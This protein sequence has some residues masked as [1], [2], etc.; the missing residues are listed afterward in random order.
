M[1]FEPPTGMPTVF[2]PSYK[3]VGQKVGL[4]IW[5]VEK[6]KI[7][8]KPENEACYQGHFHEGDAYIILQ[9]KKKNNALERHI[10]FWLGKDSS[11]DEQGVAAYKTVE[12][13]ESLGGEPV[14]H[15]EVQGHETDQFL[16]LFKGGVRYLE[17]GV[18][19]G[20]KHV[21][22]D[23]FRLR[24]LHLKGRRNV[25]CSEVKVDPKS[26]NE[27]DVF[28]ADGGRKLVLWCGKDASRVEKCKGVQMAQQIRDQERSGNAE[29]VCVE[30]GKDETAFW[31]TLGISKPARITS[32]KDGG[33]D[34]AHSRS[35]ANAIKLFK[36]SDA[37]G[38]L[39][40][41][42]ITER[43]LKKE[44]LDTNDSFVLNT[45]GGE[46]IF[47]W[48]GKKASQGEKLH[49]MKYATEYLKNSGLPNHTPI[50]RV[51]EGTETP[52]FKQSFESWPEANALKPGAV[53]SGRKS[54]EKKAFDINSMKNPGQRE[55]YHLPDDGTG[56]LQIWRIEDFE[57]AEWPKERYG[58]FYAGDS[59]V[60]LYTYLV[61]DKENYIVYFWQGLDSSQD[62]K[63]AS[64]LWAKN[65]DDELGG[66]AVQ[67]RVV[68]NKEPPHFYLIFKGKFI[69]H[70]GGKASGFKNIADKDSYDTDGVSLY[71][72]RGTNETN[73]RAIQ[74]PEKA[75]SLNSGD[76]FLL[77][78]PA[79]F[80]AW[81]GSQCSG[82]E[83][84]MANS[85]FGKVD[86][87]EVQKITEG[88]EPTPFWDALGGKAD[89][90]KVK[91][92]ADQEYREP[93]L[94]QASNNRG[95][96]YV[97][98]IFDYDQEDLIEEDVM[99]LDT[100]FEV[101]VWI[102]NGANNEEKKGALEAALQYI[103]TD[104]SS[105]SADDTPVLVI[106]QGYEPPNF[107]CHFFAWNPSKWSEGMSYEE[108][109]NKLGSG[110]LTAASASAELGKYTGNVK[111]TFAQLTSDPLPE[112]VDATKKELY[113]GDEDFKNIM[114]MTAGEFNAMPAWKR[115]NLKKKVGLY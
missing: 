13:D 56:K 51:S 110:E 71:Q 91:V 41:T 34:D 20:F 27:G 60:L 98:E 31:T 101:F 23:A 103:S 115:N 49:S 105:R 80:Y 32:S 83:R 26:I 2:D 53:P 77:T 30:Q 10:F 8:K 16:A 86:R 43:P 72:V 100:F 52:M 62:E 89:Y 102:G 88:S 11:Q 109:V 28:I 12:L 5:R 6:L 97:E 63:G 113:L 48:V 45:G 14:Q 93:R 61:N 90:A 87:R 17:G 114:G 38:S 92:S 7:V 68:Q 21:D 81:Y 111:Y 95:Y 58:E 54:F 66:A 108:M 57:R 50:A 96:F 18:A 76:I 59:Y 44:M 107:T 64:A 22:R 69:V 75:A 24:L 42:E 84:E 85:Y 67:V 37:S 47:V 78:C 29:I 70:S 9:T 55:Q 25:R 35:A 40:F 99:I 94:F 36:L 74:V 82:D 65:V 1:G 104:G 79:G 112:G 4:E 46:G 15:R 33:D 3:G 39:Q 19:T 73:T 106:K